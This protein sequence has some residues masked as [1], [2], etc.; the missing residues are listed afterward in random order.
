MRA[1]IDTASKFGRFFFVFVSAAG[2]SLTDDTEATVGRGHFWGPL[3]FGGS[4]TL[5]SSNPPVPSRS[6]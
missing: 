4:D 1:A 3:F 6:S 5:R 2:R